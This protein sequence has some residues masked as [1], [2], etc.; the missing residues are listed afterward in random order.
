MPAYRF[1]SPVLPLLCLLAATAA[2]A[3]ARSAGGFILVLCA[4]VAFNAGQLAWHKDLHHRVIGGNVGR[5][6]K[7]S[8]TWMR[9][10]FPPD[11]VIAATA[12]GAVAYFSRLRVIDMLGLNDSRIAHRQMPRM[13]RGM[14][15]H[16]KAD[17]AYV[18]SLEPD[19]ILLG[20]ALGQKKPAFM[21]GF[22]IVGQRAFKQHYRLKVIPLPSGKNL[23]VY[24]RMAE[25][26]PG[27]G[28]APRRG[29]PRP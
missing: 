6:G 24:A 18:L 14:P 16:E 7:E 8:G 22:E 11:T 20:S 3:L 12:A 17:G 21:A 4:V 25:S 1:F 15:G 27:T 5:L 19:Y 29:P 9:E 26:S 28:K 10:N 2:S 13:G 23:T